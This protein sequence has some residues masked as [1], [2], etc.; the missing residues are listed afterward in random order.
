MKIHANVTAHELATILLSL[1]DYPIFFDGMGKDIE[2]IDVSEGEISLS[3]SEDGP[4]KS[5]V[6]LEIWD[7]QS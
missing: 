1:P 3:G 4:F 6:V 7:V 5:V 2:L